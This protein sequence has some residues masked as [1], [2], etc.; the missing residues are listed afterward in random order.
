MVQPLI[1]AINGFLAIVENVPFSFHAL[2][3]LNAGMTM[4]IFLFRILHGSKG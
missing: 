4:I 1:R 2:I 3:W